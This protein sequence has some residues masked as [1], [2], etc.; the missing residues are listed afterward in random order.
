MALTPVEQK[1]WQGM[2]DA[3]ARRV[4]DLEQ[5]LEQAIDTQAELQLEIVDLKIRIEEV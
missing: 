5:K 1:R 2:Y 3:L 4:S